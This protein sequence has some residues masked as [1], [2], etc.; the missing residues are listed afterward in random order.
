MAHYC[1]SKKQ[2]G[3]AGSNKERFLR[4]KKAWGKEPEPYCYMTEAY[5]PNMETF[6]KSFF[7]PDYQ[8]RLAE[9]LKR[10]SDPLFLISE[11]IISGEN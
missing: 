5:Y 9:S 7:D 2:H 3:D 8:E 4:N 6:E 10:I 11:E 1:S